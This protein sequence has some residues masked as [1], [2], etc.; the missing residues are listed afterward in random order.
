VVHTVLKVLAGR[1][2]EIVPYYLTQES[3]EPGIA[4]EVDPEL[5][6]VTAWVLSPAEVEELFTH[7]EAKA[8]GNK[9][10][11]L[12]ERCFC[13]GLRLDGGIAACMWC[14]VHRCHSE[15]TSFPLKENEAY[16]CSAVTFKAYRGRNLAPFLRCEL[17]RYLKQM[18]RTKLYSITEFFNTPALKF[19]E[20]LG[21]KQVKLGLHIRLFN[22]CRWNITLRRYR[23]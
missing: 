1:G 7:P 20:K 2:I 18:G 11:L 21:A 13:F 14:N 9:E 8:M 10:R 6:P 17:H 3:L 4:P 16:M 22:R 12:R 23:T 5:G 19:K 15:L